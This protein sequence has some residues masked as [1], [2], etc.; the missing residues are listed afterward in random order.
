VSD[1][2]RSFYADWAG[3]NRRTAEALRALSTEDLALRVAGSDHWP[4]WAVAGHTAAARVYW[5]CHVLGEA[6]AETTPFTDPTG[7]G[8]EDDLSVVRTAEEV[9]AAYESTWRVVASCLDRWTPEMLGETFFRQGKT[10]RQMHTRQ[11]ILLRLINHE[12]YHVGEISLVLGANGREPID[13]WPPGDWVEDAPV[14]RR[15]G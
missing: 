9:A 8:W 14:S 5:L 12:A 7:F 10:T 15:E 11:S 3:Y 2:I 1:S 6:G 13:L 4:I